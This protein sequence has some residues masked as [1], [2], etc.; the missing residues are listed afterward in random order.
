VK[1]PQATST[2][3]NC[4]ILTF[5]EHGRSINPGCEIHT[6]DQTVDPGKEPQFVTHH[7]IGISSVPSMGEN[8][9][10]DVMM[11]L[12]DITEMLGHANRW[13]ATC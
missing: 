10:G 12:S 5:G 6:F 3:S 7:K 13:G 2:S 4:R 11:R 8:V 1:K 9:A